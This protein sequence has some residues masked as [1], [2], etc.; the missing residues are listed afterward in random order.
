MLAVVTGAL[1][2]GSACGGD[3]GG[4]GPNTAPVAA[5][6]A[7]SCTVNVACTFTDASTDDVAVTGWS[8]NFGDGSPTGTAQNPTHT[9]ATA[10]TYQ[11]VLTVTDAGGLTGTVTNAVTVAPP[12]NTPPTADFTYN[13]TDDNCTFTNTSTD[14]DGS[15]ATYAWD[16][17][18]P[19]SG[20]SNL[21][22]L[23]DPTHVFTAAA[24]FTVTLT[25]TDN[26]GATDVETQPISVSQGLVCTGV[27]CTLDLTSRSTVTIT[28]TAADCEFI[29]NSFEITAPI[30]EQVFADGCTLTPGTVF[31]I[32]GGAAFNAGTSL[33]ARFIQGTPPQPDDPLPGPAATRVTGEFP[34]WTVEFDDGG[35]PTAPGEP[36]YNDIVLTVNATLAP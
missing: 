20:A 36:D 10:N 4:T 22:S 34:D 19:A 30:Q 16:F 9:F 3:D 35:N 17:G 25:V 8:W 27:D 33:Q 2:L 12:A 6:T 28:V 26:L 14:A 15:I 13:C 31:T 21:S 32:N 11:V 5:F 18:D 7:P 24:T 23:E 29:N 1:V